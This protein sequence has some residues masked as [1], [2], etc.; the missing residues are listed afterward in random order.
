MA[1]KSKRLR[2][3]QELQNKTLQKIRLISVLLL[4]VKLLIIWRIS[5]LSISR[6]QGHIWLGADGENYLKGVDG[7]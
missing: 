5:N 7:F 6:V 4:F 2:Q 3:N 1:S